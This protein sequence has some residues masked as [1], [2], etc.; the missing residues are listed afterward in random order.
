MLK[1][2]KE[3][4]EVTDEGII[5]MNYLPADYEVLFNLI[6]NKSCKLVFT[7]EAGWL[8]LTLGMQDWMWQNKS[9]EEYQEV[10]D[11]ICSEFKANVEQINL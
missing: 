9:I 6:I 11:F 7:S 5:M 4:I 8:S 2:N 3:I 10:T 1:N